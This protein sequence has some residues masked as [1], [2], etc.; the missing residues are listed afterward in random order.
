MVNGE[1]EMRN[2]E[3][4][5]GNGERISKANIWLIANDQQPIANG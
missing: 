1:L 4:G 2:E 3:W 5:M